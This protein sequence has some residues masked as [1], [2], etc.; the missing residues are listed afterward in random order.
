MDTNKFLAL[1]IETFGGSF[2]TFPQ[3][4][5]VL[6]V[7]IKSCFGYTMYTSEPSS[8]ELMR[9]DLTDFSGTI[10]T[11]NGAKFDIPLLEKCVEETLGTTL[12][13]SCHYDL[14]A[15][16]HKATG[17]RISL[18]KLSSFTTGAQKLPWDHRQNLRVWQEAPEEMIAYNKVDLD[19]TYDLYIRVLNGQHLFLGDT[20][21]ILTH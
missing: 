16:I 6:L 7:G 13:I 5:E 17:R 9:S 18:D 1:D 10:V 19:L 2:A 14:L 20:S 8:L 11:F 3:G 4:F 21:V 12:K 15:E